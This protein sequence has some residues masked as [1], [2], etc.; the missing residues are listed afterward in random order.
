MH[1]LLITSRTCATRQPIFVTTIQPS[2]PV[3]LSLCAL[4]R[5][6]LCGK[7][8]VP[9]HRLM[10]CTASPAYTSGMPRRLCSECRWNSSTCIIRTEGSE[11]QEDGGWVRCRLCRPYH[12]CEAQGAVVEGLAAAP[13]DEGP[14]A[15]FGEIG[16]VMDVGLVHLQQ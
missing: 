3:W 16:H 14:Y 12:L 6:T 8:V 1:Q 15:V 11:D 9:R 10:P 2:G 7:M 4:P 13:G 5:P